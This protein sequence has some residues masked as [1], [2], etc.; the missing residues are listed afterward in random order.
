ML[1]FFGAVPHHSKVDDISTHPFVGLTLSFIFL[2][3]NF[4]HSSSEVNCFRIYCLV[5]NV[6]LQSPFVCPVNCAGPANVGQSRVLDKPD[7]EPFVVA[8]T[9]FFCVCMSIW[10]QKLLPDTEEV[11][12]SVCVTAPLDDT[13]WPK[14]GRENVPNSC[15]PPEHPSSC[16]VIVT[17]TPHRNVLQYSHHHY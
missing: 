9:S 15:P 3:F 1:S 2:E 4:G 6:S 13:C 7:T 10:K 17:V 5:H 14:S 12:V 8:L 11:W 16:L